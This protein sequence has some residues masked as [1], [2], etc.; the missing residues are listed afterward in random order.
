MTGFLLRR[1]AWGL[2][3]LVIFITIVFFAVHLIFPFDY[4]ATLQGV[5]GEVAQQ[6]RAER[7]LDRPLV[8]QYVDYLTGL[9]TLDMGE[10]YVSRDPVAEILLGQPLVFTLLIF[11]LGGILAY[12]LGSW[13]G[14]MVA[15]RRGRVLAS[16]TTTIG[17]LAYT[18]FPPWLVFL[19]AYFLTEPLRRMRSLTGLP[20]DSLHVWQESSW[21]QSTILWR[22]LITLALALAVAVAIR[23]ILRRLGF[24]RATTLM[25]LV[26]PMAAAVVSWYRQGFGQEAVDLMFRSSVAAPVGRGS[27]LLVFAAFVLLAFGEIAFVVR[28]SIAA[29][30][31][32]QYVTTG[33]AKG[34]SE[35]EIRERHVTPNALLPALSRFFV[36]IP[37]IFTG[38]IIIEREFALQGLSS[39]LFSAVEN[40]DVPVIVGT[41]VIIGALV[42]AIRLVLEVVHAA[43]DP[44]IRFADPEYEA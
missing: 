33:R 35:L 24:L 23:G 26:V 5:G 4:V 18:A 44:R 38:L 14:K 42:L 13:L 37:Y 9:A 40:V 6:M 8:V 19:L 11:V 12:F 32:E 1:A 30:R 29:E 34:L 36:S 41:L 22:V 20:A 17:V 15:W 28:T 3:T 25:A 31:S 10:S 2:V 21:E 27:I 39:V 16:G 43:V 7:G